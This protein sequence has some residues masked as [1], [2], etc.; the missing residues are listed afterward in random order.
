MTVPF[1]ESNAVLSIPCIK[2]GLA[3]VGGGVLHVPG[4]KVT[5]C[6]VSREQRGG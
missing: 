2:D 4:G 3:R 5:E 1:I 6:G